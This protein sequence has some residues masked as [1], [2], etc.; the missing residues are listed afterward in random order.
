VASH[1]TATDNTTSL[2]ITADAGYT[3]TD[4]VNDRTLFTRKDNT[5]N[6]VSTGVAGDIAAVRAAND[7]WYALVLT[8]LGHDVVLAAAAHIETLTKIMIVAS[9][10]DGIYSGGST[11][12]IAYVLDAASYAR[13]AIM[14]HPYAA[15]QYPHAAWI[16]KCLPKDPGSITW[17]FKTLAGITVTYLT[18][19]ELSA[20][21]AKNCNHYTSI[22]NVS[23]TQQGKSCSGEFIDITQSIDFMKARLQEYVYAPLVNADKIPYTD[24]GAAVIEAEIRAVLNLCIRQGILAASPAPTVTVPKVADQA[25]T[26]RANRYFPDITFTG[27]LAGA[28]HS[29]EVTGTLSV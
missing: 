22:A 11:T 9:A 27:T 26:D 16:G 28:I 29:L 3:F 2:D 23:V 8:N 5:P 1:V 7:D 20:I 14:Y 10:A 24:A 21:E 12:D 4:Y 18:P 6:T 15:Y 25:T 13:T 17:K 19:T